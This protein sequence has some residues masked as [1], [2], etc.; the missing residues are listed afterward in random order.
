MMDLEEDTV[1]AFLELGEDIPQY[2]QP[3]ATKKFY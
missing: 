3:V 2:W 1:R